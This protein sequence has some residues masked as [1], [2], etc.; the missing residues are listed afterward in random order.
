MLPR[1]EID[2]IGDRF[3]HFKYGDA[4]GDQRAAFARAVE[5]AAYAAAI[6]A[7]EARAEHE[8]EARAL[9]R[10]DAARGGD[11]NEELARLRHLSDVR[12]FN[13]GISM[14]ADAIRSL[15]REQPK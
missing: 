8:E 15:M 5:Q 7:C 11:V 13:A 1:D 14:C 10:A 4:Q 12:L 3:G 9:Q 2:A 6:K